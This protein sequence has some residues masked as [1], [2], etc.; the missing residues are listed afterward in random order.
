[1]VLKLNLGLFRRKARSHPYPHGGN[2]KRIVIFDFDGTLAQTLYPSREIINRLADEFGYNKVH[3][4]EIEYIRGL[5]PKELLKY[6]KIPGMKL[7]FIAK[8]TKAELNKIIHNLKPVET[9]VKVIFEL[10]NRGYAVAILT[11]NTYENVSKFCENNDIY[12]FD[13]VVSESNLFG[14]SRALK[15]MLRKIKYKRNEAI[16]IGDEVRDVQAAKKAK[17][18]VVAVSWG[19]NNKQTLKKFKPTFV[20][21]DPKELLDILAN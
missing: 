4:H 17:I 7:P 20:I 2:K 11:S 1:M 15:R 6:L 13:H 14:K 16:Y 3:E 10:K 19:F 8:K 9:I 18:D 5:R 12:L 21:D